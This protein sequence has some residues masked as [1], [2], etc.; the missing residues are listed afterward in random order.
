MKKNRTNFKFLFLAFICICFGNLKS[1]SLSSIN[2]KD[3][4]ILPPHGMSVNL[5]ADS[6]VY[7][8]TVKIDD[9]NSVSNVYFVL[10]KKAYPGTILEVAATVVK[11]NSKYFIVVGNKRYLFTNYTILLP[12]NLSKDQFGE[13]KEIAFYLK[14]KSGKLTPTLHTFIP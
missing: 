4:D 12:V 14:E 5:A 6:N 11:E 9:I 2:V 13:L 8:L 7:H 10:G 3:L 1:Q